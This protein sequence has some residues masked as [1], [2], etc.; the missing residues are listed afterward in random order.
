MGGQIAVGHN[1]DQALALRQPGNRLAQV[2]ADHPLDRV[3]DGDDAVERTVF[4]DPLGRRLGPHLVDAGHVVDRVADQRQV[5]DHSL[6]R[7]AEFGQHACLVEHPRA[8]W[9]SC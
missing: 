6:G 5:V 9:P 8:A 3:G 7:Y 2:V 4:G 1:G